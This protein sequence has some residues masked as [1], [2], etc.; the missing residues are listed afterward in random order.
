MGRRQEDSVLVVGL[1]RF[2]AAMAGTLERLG[3]EVLAVDSDPELVEEWTGQLAHV[4][5]AD[6]TS[7]SAMRQLGAEQFDIAVV[8]DC[9]RLS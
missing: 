5:Q 2:G 8:G 3:H 4:V 1:G 9:C 7:E 6:S